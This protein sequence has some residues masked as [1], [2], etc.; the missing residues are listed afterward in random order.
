MIEL[1]EELQRAVQQQ[2]LTPLHLIDP[3][4]KE[5]FVLIRAKEY[6]R[7]KEYD[8]SPWTDDEMDRLAAEDADTLGWDGMEAYQDQE[9]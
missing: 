5:E 3:T 8:N 1:S 4:T 7:L 6:D 2:S 9:S